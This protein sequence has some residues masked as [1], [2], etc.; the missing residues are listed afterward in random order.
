MERDALEGLHFTR[1]DAADVWTAVHRQLPDA[2][3]RTYRPPGHE[4]LVGVEWRVW[5]TNSL[6]PPVV[7]LPK[8]PGSHA[9]W[10]T[11]AVLWG[12]VT[13]RGTGGQVSTA[14][15]G[16]VI[17]TDGGVALQL[18]TEPLTTHMVVAVLQWGIERPQPWRDPVAGAI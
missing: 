6:C 3:H 7:V 18:T 4:R 2:W 15:W 10:E 11:G 16:T 12:W 8:K 14:P 17:K 5:A 13:V 1:A 9:S